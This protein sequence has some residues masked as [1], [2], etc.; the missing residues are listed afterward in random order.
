M[1]I[2]FGN[3]YP[4]TR[5]KW[6][7]SC[8][9]A[10]IYMNIRPYPISGRVDGDLLRNKGLGALILDTGACIYCIYSGAT[11]VIELARKVHHDASSTKQHD[12]Q[13][14]KG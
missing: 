5:I 12:C 3:W 4:D 11:P 9:L 13:Y 1:E 2:I 14:S 6:I 7:T 8:D 10:I